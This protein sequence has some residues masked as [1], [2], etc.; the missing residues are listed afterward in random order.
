MFARLMFTQT[1][2]SVLL[3]TCW[4][5]FIAALVL[6][7]YYFSIPPFLFGHHLA[8]AT[9]IVLPWL[10]FSLLIG[11]LSKAFQV[12]QGYWEWVAHGLSA[13]AFMLFH[14]GL[15]TLSYWLFRPQIVESVSFAYVYGEQLVKWFPFEY[16][17][18]GSCLLLWHRST[19]TSDAPP[20]SDAI[21]TLE[22]LSGIVKL[23]QDD[24]LWV[25]ADDNYVE[26]G[27]RNEVWRCRMTLRA[28]HD[29]VD[30]EQ[31]IQTHRSALVN[32][33]YVRQV[34]ANRV[35]LVNGQR[36]VLSR[37]RR[38]DVVSKLAH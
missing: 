17:I 1:K 37:R 19:N 12:Q 10:V 23:Q 33:K 31:F 16:L 34:M 11:S 21:V 9:Y 4:L 18:Y 38:G 29:L 6:R 26:V 25:Q 14:V 8:E 22:S 27:T 2:I 35:V 5:G 36:I 15:L 13:T 32:T 24:I 20:P 28:M 30:P 7:A 3:V